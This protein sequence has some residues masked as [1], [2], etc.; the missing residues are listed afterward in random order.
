M[1]VSKSACHLF[2]LTD[3]DL[4]LIYIL[5]RKMLIISEEDN[6]SLFSLLN[7]IIS[8]AVHDDA[9]KATSVKNIK[10]MFQVQIL[11]GRKSLM[12]KWKCQVLNLSVFHELLCSADAVSMSSTAS[13]SVSTWITYLK[14]LRQK[15]DF[16]HAFTQYELWHDLLNVINSMSDLDSQFLFAF[17]LSVQCWSYTLSIDSASVFVQN[18]LFD[19][20]Q[21]AVSYY[22]N[23]KIQF[24]TEFCYLRKSFNEVIQKMVRLA[25]LTADMSASTELSSE[26][27]TELKQHS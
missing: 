24:D 3:T 8:L 11:S 26:Q 7:H 14:C 4:W 6:D 9:F 5:C 25:S 16:K 10:N 27:K 18:Q 13:L 1:N 12:L 15:A 19:H 20:Q 23:Q 22:L 2:P 17:K 21:R